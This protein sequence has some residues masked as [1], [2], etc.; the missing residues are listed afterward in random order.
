MA[1]RVKSRPQG[2]GRKCQ[3]CAHEHRGRIDYLIVTGGARRGSGRRALAEKYGVTEICVRNHAL[4]HITIEYRRAVL[5]GPLA[6]TE[7][8]KQLVAEE[9]ISVLQNFRALYNGHRERWLLGLEIGDDNMMV[10]HGR[11]MSEMLWKIGRLTQEIAPPQQFVQNNTVQIFDNPEY[12]AA[13]TALT[14]ALKPF[15]EARAAAAEALRQIDS[16]SKPQL[17]VIEGKAS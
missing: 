2:G 7:D 6:N 9:N 11:A 5:A 1:R 17:K 16:K 13:I 3:I 8:L 4:R 14:T 10:Q 15:P 12:L